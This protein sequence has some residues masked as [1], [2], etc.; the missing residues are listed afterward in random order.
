MH[1]PEGFEKFYSK[2]LLLQLLKALYGTKQAAM[3][4]WIELLKCMMNM[5]YARS[6]VDP[7]LYYKWTIYG[8]VVWLSWIDDCMCWGPKNVVQKENQDF[9]D[10]F[11]CNDV[12]EVKE[13]V[14]CKIKQVNGYLKFT[15][16]VMLQSFE[17]KFKTT[18]EAKHI[19]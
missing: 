14:G 8:L 3:A 18:E 5:M 16:P 12:G 11:D 10:C 2:D 6:G 1:V 9:M 17:D 7:C 15:Q 13:Y 4:F 19:G